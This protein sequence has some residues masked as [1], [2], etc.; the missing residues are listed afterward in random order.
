MRKFWKFW[1]VGGGVNFGGQFWK[2][3]RGGGSYCKSLPWGWYGHFLEPHNVFWSTCTAEVVS[4]FLFTFF[5]SLAYMYAIHSLIRLLKWTLWISKDRD[6]FFYLWN[7]Q[8]DIPNSFREITFKRVETLQ[9]MSG[10][11]NVFATQQ[12]YSFQ[13][14][15]FPL[16]LF[17]KSWKLCKLPKLT[18]PF[19]PLNLICSYSKAFYGLTR[20][21]VS[22]NVNNDVSKDSPIKWVLKHYFR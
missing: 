8:P 16:L 3:Q 1:R 5:A 19:Q 13:W 14:L 17:A 18:Q 21:I 7:F 20:K 11:I 9:R 10:L 15:L 12:F 4:F 22:K 2:I 6:N